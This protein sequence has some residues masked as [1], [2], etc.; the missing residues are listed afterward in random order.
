MTAASCRIEANGTSIHCAVSGAGAPVVLIHGAEADHSMFDG[1]AALLAA[2]FTVIAY[3]QRDSGSTRNPPAPYGLAEMA[4][5]AAALIASLGHERAHV[6]GTSLGGVI[7]QVLAARHPRRVDRLV[8]SSTF[9]PGVPP[10]T[11]NPDV[12]SRLAALRAGLPHT[13][14][15]I[16]T[17]FFPPGHIAA[18]PET[19]A[20]FNG[21]GR[22]PEQRQRRAGIL[23]RP[24][25]YDPQ[26]IAAPTLVLAG[27]DDRLIPPAHTLSL[28]GDIPGARTAT[29]AGL[30][31]VGTLQAPD[32][33]AREVV[34]FLTTRNGGNEHGRT[35][36]Q[37]ARAS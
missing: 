8:L 30:G 15:E 32:Q 19:V 10:L 26:Q 29:L 24:V 21:T 20:I 18:H 33:V 25:A 36:E 4:D 11:I 34:A 27:A 5:D 16:A 28:A 35:G 3:D 2:H 22:T 17:Y 23:A 9:R 6:F 14:A 12:F 31:H 13:A 7:A 1:F 37:S